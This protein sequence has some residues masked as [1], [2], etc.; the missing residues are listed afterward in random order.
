MAASAKTVG[1]KRYHA[2]LIGSANIL[3]DDAEAGLLDWIVVVRRKPQ[4]H[5]RVSDPTPL[6]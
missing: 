6:L 4:W 5:A 2:L 3:S 1:M